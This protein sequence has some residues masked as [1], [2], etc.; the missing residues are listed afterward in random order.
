MKCRDIPSRKMVETVRELAST[1]IFEGL[2]IETIVNMI[3]TARFFGLGKKRMEAY[4]KCLCE[5]RLE[6]LAYQKDEILEEKM[7]EEAE[8]YGI[9]ID[10]LFEDIIPHKELMRRERVRAKNVV[11]ISQA[12]QM[13]EQLDLM[14]Q[15][16]EEQ[17]S[18]MKITSL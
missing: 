9:E 14:K 4:R 5:T 17:Q 7:Q 2:R 16:Q 13:T 15:F 8:K 12:K 3:A 10:N 1:E 18:K 6:Y 11:S